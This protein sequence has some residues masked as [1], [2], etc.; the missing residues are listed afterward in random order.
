MPYL[1]RPADQADEGGGVVASYAD[2]Y[3]RATIHRDTADQRI[4]MR[5][6]FKNQVF[7]PGHN[8]PTMSLDEL[9]EI[10][11]NDAMGRQAKEQE[12]ERLAGL[13]DPESEEVMER[14]R[15]RQSEMADWKD[16]VPKGR[17]ITQ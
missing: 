14:E 10:E 5:A 2:P 16:Y 17:G 1:M 15:K 9:A 3:Q 11:Y 4:D 12:Q 8:M 6:Q 7:K 13:E